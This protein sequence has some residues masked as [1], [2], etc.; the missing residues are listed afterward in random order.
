MLSKSTSNEVNS[1]LS[2][3]E[4]EKGYKVTVITTRKLEFDPDAFAFG[5]KILRKWSKGAENAESKGIFLVVT[6][7]KDGAVVGGD[8][9]IRVRINDKDNP[10]ST[11]YIYFTVK[12]SQ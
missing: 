6:T 5:E 7:A 2:R 11:V 12:V 1:V 8:K 4:K 3:L 9:F 10:A